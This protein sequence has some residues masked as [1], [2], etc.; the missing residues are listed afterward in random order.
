VYRWGATHPAPDRNAPG[1]IS[2]SRAFGSAHA[3]GFNCAF[4]DGSVRFIR[5]SVS[6]ATWERA[7]V[8]N[9]NQ[10]LGPNDF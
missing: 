2:A 10:A 5:Y 4:G 7:C 6:P 8:R 1:D 3:S 9:D